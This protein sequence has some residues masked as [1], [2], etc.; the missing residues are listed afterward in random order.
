[1]DDFSQSETEIEPEVAIVPGV[2]TARKPGPAHFVHQG[3]TMINGRI[4]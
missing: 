2:L 4:G 1:M 3:S